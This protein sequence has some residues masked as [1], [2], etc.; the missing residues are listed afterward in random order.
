MARVLTILFLGFCV[1][2]PFIHTPTAMDIALSPRLLALSIFGVVLAFFAYRTGPKAGF[3]FPDKVA[4]TWLLLLSAGFLLNPLWSTTPYESLFYGYKWLLPIGL[5]FL[6]KVIS[7]K[8]LATETMVKGLLLLGGV[9]ALL[10]L[11]Q[12]GQLLPIEA[13]KSEYHYGGAMINENLLASLLVMLLPLGLA[14]ERLS[15]GWQWGSL[16]IFVAM[17]AALLVTKSKAAIGVGLFVLVG[18]WIYFVRQPNYRKVSLW[19]GGLFALSAFAG[20]LY[21]KE[22]EP[23]LYAGYLATDTFLLRLH[24]WENTVQMIFDYP[25]LGVGFGAWKVMMPAYGLDKF[26]EAVYSGGTSYVRAHNQLLEIASEG[27]ILFGLAFLGFLAY[28]VKRGWSCISTQKEDTKAMV[29]LGTIGAVLLALVD[30]PFERAT[31]VFVLSI[32]VAILLPS[33]RN[34]LMLPKASLLVWPV[35]F[36]LIGWINVQHVKGEQRSKKLHHYYAQQSFNGLQATLRKPTPTIYTLDPTVV[37]NGFFAGMVNFVSKDFRGAEKEFQKS[38]AIHPNHLITLNNLG[39]VYKQKGEYNT[40]AQYYKKARTISKKYLR[41]TWNLIEVYA[42]S[43][44]EDSALALLEELPQNFNQKEYQYL[45]NLIT[46][47]YLQK[48]LKEYPD[49]QYDAKYMRKM[50][51]P[52]FRKA[53]YLDSLRIQRGV[54]F[55][56]WILPFNSDTLK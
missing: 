29:L 18:I 10:A 21:I 54:S 40:A 23:N 50:K 16:A 52:E 30:F 39:A 47:K 3:S 28:V 55:Y 14:V 27:G 4:G 46:E 32:Y 34:S 41:P 53:M 51:N 24:L 22:T 48:A 44:K 42:L 45:F 6:W 20:V 33:N 12:W 1:V 15:K 13:Y 35:L 8:L 7:P 49:L 2:F 5:I 25:L 38:L 31:H 9:H 17:I 36:A 43:G 19:L 37:P 11:L 26:D 56:R